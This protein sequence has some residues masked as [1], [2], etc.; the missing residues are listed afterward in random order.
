MGDS[1]ETSTMVSSKPADDVEASGSSNMIMMP[2][3]SALDLFTLTFN[4]AKNLINVAVFASHL[5]TAFQK[6]ATTLPEVVV[7]CVSRCFPSL[8]PFA[9][10]FLEGSPTCLVPLMSPRTGGCPVAMLPL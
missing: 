7:L 2:S 3:M 8:S 9:F 6:N 1:H 10:P 5:Q 4:C